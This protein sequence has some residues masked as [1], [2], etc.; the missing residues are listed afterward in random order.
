VKLKRVEFRNFKLL[1]GVVIEFSTDRQRP[2]TVVRAENGSGKTSLLWGLAWAFYGDDGLPVKNA[3]LGST[4]RPTGGTTNVRVIVD[5]EHDP[6]GFGDINHYVLSRSVDET[7]GEGDHVEHGP[8]QTQL[9]IRKAAGDEPV[10]GDA[11]AILERF[12]PSRLK[13]TFLTDGDRVQRFISGTVAAKERQH[14]VHQAIKALLGLDGLETVEADINKV[15][16][17]FRKEMAATSGDEVK[18]AADALDQCE[19][20][21]KTERTKRLATE[22]KRSKIEES[23]AETEKELSEMTGHGDLD[24]INADIDAATTG[25]KAAEKDAASLHDEIR[26]LFKSSEDLSWSLANE[27]LQRGHAVLDGLREQGVIPGSSLGVIRDR[28]DMG[29][30]IC[31]ESLADGSSH[32]D[33]VLALLDEQAKISEQR[34]RLTETYHRTRAG[35]EAFETTAIDERD[36]WAK[37]PRLLERH[38]EVNERIRDNDRKFAEGEERR[39]GIREDDI[40]RLTQRLETNR[41]HKTQESQNIGAHDNELARLEDQQAVLQVRYEK[42]QNAAK[43]DA[44]SKNRFDIS[45]DLRKVVEATLHTLKTDHVTAVSTRMNEIFMEIVGSDPEMVGAVF[46]KVYLTDS[47]DIVVEAVVDDDS[48]TRTLDTDYEVNGASQRALTLAFIWGLMEVANTVAPRVID[49]P[50]GM[51]AGGV[52]NRMVE[53]ITEPAASDALDYQVVLLLTRSEIRDIEDILDE[54]AGKHITLTCSKDY[55]TDLVNSWGVTE[56][57]VRHCACTHRQFCETCERQRDGDHRL[58]RRTANV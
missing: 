36:F 9:M 13:D 50:L 7:A 8:M 14:N 58:V 12:V 32:R 2:L 22:T 6:D 46:K 53:A 29:K 16:S 19:Q 28:L 30:C 45:D 39:K 23:I 37:R 34:E 49:T 41:R 57:T 25:K 18:V 48:Q 43:S 40:Q 5:F 4:S 55:P 35:I 3:R 31:G 47:F 33:H 10:P 17:D 38:T 26:N 44:T 1:D 52:K 24:Q 42:A 20:D 15:A 51:T 11:N 27:A 54:R 21:L 56:P